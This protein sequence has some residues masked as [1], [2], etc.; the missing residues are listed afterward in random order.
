MVELFGVCVENCL[1]LRSKTARSIPQGC[2]GEA[3]QP[4]RH[5]MF[6][7]RSLPRLIPIRWRR[8]S[9]R[10]DVCYLG[11]ADDSLIFFRLRNRLLKEFFEQQR[12]SE[13][14]REREVFGET[15]SGLVHLQ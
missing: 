11:A 3:V 14:P 1:K 15:Q 9:L 4:F 5:H 13:N 6:E 12:K 10:G 8:D 7:I 2:N